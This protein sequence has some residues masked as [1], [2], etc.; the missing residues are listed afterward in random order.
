MHFLQK[1]CVHGNINGL[2]K[3]SKHTP[4]INSASMV[5]PVNYFLRTHHPMIPLATNLTYH[6]YYI[7]ILIVTRNY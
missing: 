2:S 6:A 5:G 3:Y 7:M 4:H 1:L